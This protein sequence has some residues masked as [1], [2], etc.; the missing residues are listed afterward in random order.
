MNLKE[1][2]RYQNCLR[3][4]WSETILALRNQNNITKIKQEHLRKKANPDAEDDT[5]DLAEERRIPCGADELV[6]FLAYLAKER[7]RLTDAIAAAK[8]SSEFDFDAEKAKNSFRQEAANALMAMARTKPSKTTKRGT[9]YK[10]NVEGV[11]SPYVYDI[12]ETTEIDFDVNVVRTIAR[13]LNDH[14]DKVSTGLDELI[15]NLHVDYVPKFNLSDTFEE[16]LNTFLASIKI[17]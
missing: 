1:S 7:E 10:F 14:S 8:R 9:A 13:E 16:A 4:L 15:V 6:M 3:D 5:T 2:F 12:I 17:D 11:Q